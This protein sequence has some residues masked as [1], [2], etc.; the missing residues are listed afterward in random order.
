MEDTTYNDV[1]RMEAD[2]AKKVHFDLDNNTYHSV[3]AYSD[4]F[5]RHPRGITISNNG[6]QLLSSNVDP[7]T[8]MSADVM[9]HRRE[10]IDFVTRPKSRIIGN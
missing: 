3:L 7:F 6:M 5:P 9:I 2:V 8:S 4:Q 1:A 10:D